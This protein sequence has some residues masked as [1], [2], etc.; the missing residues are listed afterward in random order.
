MVGDPQLEASFSASAKVTRGVDGAGLG[1]SCCT[2]DFSFDCCGSM[3]NVS[4]RDAGVLNVRN[5]VVGEIVGFAGV[6][7]L[8]G[9]RLPFRLARARGSI[10][11]RRRLPPRGTR[12]V[13]MA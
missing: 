11:L 5:S 1:S 8:A 10:D 4:R 13:S 2:E 12:D 9:T 3:M 7:L 6:A